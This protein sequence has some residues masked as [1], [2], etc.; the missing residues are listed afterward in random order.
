MAL[1]ATATESTLSVVID[2]LAMNNPVVIG[3]PPHSQNIK[4]AVK[5]LPSVNDFCITTAAEL[6]RLGLEYPKTVTFCRKYTLITELY[7]GL[8]YHIG[9]HFTSP[10]PP[11]PMGLLISMNFV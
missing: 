11:P 2:R 4:Y 10:P 6:I 5:P 3:L 1:T 8:R 7:H 9:Q